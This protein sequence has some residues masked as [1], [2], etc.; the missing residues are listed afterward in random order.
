[1]YF[2]LFLDPLANNI[3]Y[4]LIMAPFRISS[5]FKI[6]SKKCT[7]CFFSVPR[8]QPQK[9][10]GKAVSFDYHYIKGNG[11][12]EHRLRLLVSHFNIGLFVFLKHGQSAHLINF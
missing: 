12:L 9:S 10:I 1:M 7:V 8:H 6:P 11:F 3:F 4:C 5:S 2:G